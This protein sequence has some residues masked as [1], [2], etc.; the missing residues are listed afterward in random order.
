MTATKLHTQNAAVSYQERK[1]N[2]AHSQHRF[3]HLQTSEV[4]TKNYTESVI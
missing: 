4:K 1:K 3:T 2:R